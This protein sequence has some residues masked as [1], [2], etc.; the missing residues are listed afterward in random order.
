VVGTIRDDGSNAP[1]STRIINGY[2]RI[3]QPAPVSA[4]GRRISADDK[5]T[6]PGGFAASH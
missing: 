3:Y 5:K 1:E 4:A 2:K 6:S